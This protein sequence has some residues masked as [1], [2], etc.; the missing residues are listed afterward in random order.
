M[1]IGIYMAY[2]PLVALGKEGL[3][4]YIGNL[5]KGFVDAGHDVTIACPKWSLDTIDDLF[6]DFQIDSSKVN[7]L[8]SQKKVSAIWRLYERK[9]KKRYPKRSI[10]YKLFNSLADFFTWIISTIISITSYICLAVVGIPILALAVLFSPIII[11]VFLTCFVVRYKDKIINRIKIKKKI[12][13]KNIWKSLLDFIVSSSK[14]KYNNLNT[15]L[16]ESRDIPIREDLIKIINRNSNCDVWFVPSLFWTE[17]SNI[18][19]TKVICAP[20]IV[21]QEFPIIFSENSA[22]I[23]STKTCEEVLFVEKYFI[24]YC[25][26]LRKKL[27]IESYG[28]NSKHVIS[29]PHINNSMSSYIATSN[30]ANT[31][32]DYSLLLSEKIFSSGMLANCHTV[33]NRYLSNFNLIII[34]VCF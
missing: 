5:I 7:F 6:Q 32:I 8:V 25:E 34:H 9:Y 31:D 26:Y 14:N 2:S 16:N 3:G 19:S 1:K 30:P 17:V 29:I 12:N 27:V 11:L 33:D 28:K 18:N 10:K 22:F 20:D 23:N 15:L 24:T 4:R 13:I 21:T